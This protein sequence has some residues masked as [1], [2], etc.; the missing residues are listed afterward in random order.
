MELS[1]RDG[2]VADLGA[3][4]KSHLAYRDDVERQLQGAPSRQPPESAPAGMAKHERVCAAIILE[5]SRE[6][7]NCLDRALGADVSISS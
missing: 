5:H 7:L 4:G 6:T 2:A 3:A 1:K